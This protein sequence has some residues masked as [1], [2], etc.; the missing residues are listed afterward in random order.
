MMPTSTKD[1]AGDKEKKKGVLERLPKLSRASQTILI[2]AMLV[3]MF[4]PTY[5]I[6]YQQPKTRAT[7]QASL[8]SLQKVLATE[9]TPK[10]K[11]EAEL[12]KVEDENKAAKASYPDASQVPELVNRLMAL[13]K[14][15]GAT[16]TGTKVAITTL[17]PP[18]EKSKTAPTERIDTILN[19]DLN[20]KGQVPHFQNFLLALDKEFPTTRIK[21]VAFAI[22]SEEGKEDTCE[23]S[24]LVLCYP[25]EKT[26]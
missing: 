26:K 15:N 21:K 24:L 9:E 17:P 23:L 20:L 13:A 22:H 4:L 2:L 6:Y 3:A 14:E 18:K 19:I 16:V 10:A 5:L 12:I 8:A 11:L 7:L 1:K 25:A